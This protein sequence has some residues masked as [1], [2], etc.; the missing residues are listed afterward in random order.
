MP[1]AEVYAKYLQLTEGMDLHL[2]TEISS[3]LMSGRNMEEIRP[4][5]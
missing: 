4:A 1:I 2:H 5:T 3:M